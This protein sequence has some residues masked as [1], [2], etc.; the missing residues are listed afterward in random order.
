M[1][2][3]LLTEKGGETWGRGWGR[4]RRRAAA[5]RRRRRGGRRRAGVGDGRASFGV[6]GNLGGSGT[7]RERAANTPSAPRN[8]HS[9]R[10]GRPR[11]NSSMGVSVRLLRKILITLA[12][13]THN[14]PTLARH[15]ATVGVGRQNLQEAANVLA[16]RCVKRVNGALITPLLWH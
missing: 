13:T 7:A 9:N 14:Q 12:F 2:R 5:Q 3:E 11:C 8:R 15:S 4:E 6:L 10:I 1:T 16:L